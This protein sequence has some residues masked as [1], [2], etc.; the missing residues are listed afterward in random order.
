M[1]K[2][3]LHRNGDY[4]PYVHRVGFDALELVIHQ[5]TRIADALQRLA[6][7]S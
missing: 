3:L 4:E 7:K 2:K 6:A 5:L 1:S